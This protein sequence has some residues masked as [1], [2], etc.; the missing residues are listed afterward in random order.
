MVSQVGADANR[1]TAQPCFF[2]C[3]DGIPNRFCKGSTLLREHS[4]GVLI[5]SH[6]GRTQLVK[7]I[8]SLIQF[9]NTL[10]EVPSERGV[11]MKVSRLSSRYVYVLSRT[12]R[13][14]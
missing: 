8:R 6:P 7:L 9:S 11:T 4:S 1:S 12:Y 13:T 3:D 5:T 14:D 2:Y 10:E